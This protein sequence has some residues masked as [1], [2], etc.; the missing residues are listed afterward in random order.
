MI[1][2][3]IASFF[4]MNVPNYIENSL[5]AMPL[6]IFGSLMVSV[7]SVLLFRKRQWF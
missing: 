4:G 7:I 6:I 1:P 5:W 2:T 3:L